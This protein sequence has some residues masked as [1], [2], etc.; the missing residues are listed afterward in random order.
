MQGQNYN[1]IYYVIIKRIPNDCATKQDNLQKIMCIC[2][3][4]KMQYMKNVQIPEELLF[5]K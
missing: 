5:Y 2:E 4:K 3:F 1:I